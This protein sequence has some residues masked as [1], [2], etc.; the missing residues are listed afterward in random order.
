MITLKNRLPTR[1]AAWVRASFRQLR[2]LKILYLLGYKKIVSPL[3]TGAV[4]DGVRAHIGQTPPGLAR[5]DAGGEH[6][7]HLGF[8]KGE[9]N[10]SFGQMVCVFNEHAHHPP[11]PTT[12]SR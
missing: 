10:E 1:S 11:L 3:I 9:T 7:E 6:L 5:V 8:R 2:N 4:H 12:P